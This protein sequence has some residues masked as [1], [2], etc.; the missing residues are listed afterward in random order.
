[1]IAARHRQRPAIGSI[2]KDISMIRFRS[3]GQAMILRPEGQRQI[4][5]AAKRVI[6]WWIVRRE[7]VA[8]T[9]LT[10]PRT[11]RQMAQDPN[12]LT[13]RKELSRTDLPAVVNGTYQRWAA[14]V[15]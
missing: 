11:R 2:V 8:Q 3:M 12:T 15:R 13:D 10:K 9:K 4:V 5:A 14:G 6:R 7:A 1:M